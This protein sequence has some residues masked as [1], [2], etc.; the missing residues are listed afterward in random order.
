MKRPGRWLFK[1]AAVASFVLCMVTVMLSVRSYFV[2]DRITY[3]KVDW[4]TGSCGEYAWRADQGAMRMEYIFRFFSDIEGVKLF[5]ESLPRQHQLIGVSISHGRPSE[6]SHSNDSILD[7]LGIWW[8][9]DSGGPSAIVRVRPTTMSVGQMSFRR[10]IFRM[11]IWPVAMALSIL[12]VGQFALLY[13]RRQRAR[14]GQCV[15]CGHDLL[16][17]ADACVNCRAIVLAL[18]GMGVKQRL[19][20]WLNGRPL[21]R[22]VP[23]V[24]KAKKFRLTPLNG[25]AIAAMALA[26]LNLVTG[27]RHLIEA[28]RQRG[29]LATSER[30]AGINDLVLAGLCIVVAF[31]CGIAGWIRRS[32]RASALRLEICATCGYDLRATPDRCPECGTTAGTS[33][34]Q[35]H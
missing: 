19:R 3:H 9:A 11:P 10:G 26:L 2:S 18:Q 30:S 15:A 25:I 14:A 28:P 16:G 29:Y 6:F 31:F 5:V 1:L 33:D 12:P 7:T 8:N 34:E 13:R 35:K 23:V 32:R 21:Y 20:W 24:S 17:S 22:G 27:V 4:K